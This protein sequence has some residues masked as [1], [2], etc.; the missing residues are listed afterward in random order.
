MTREVVRNYF[1]Q[2]AFVPCRLHLSHGDVMLIDHPEYVTPALDCLTVTVP[3]AASTD[4]HDELI[5]C[6]HIAKIEQFISWSAGAG[7]PDA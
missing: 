2:F 7:E 5:D 3:H 6:P 4:E 1:R